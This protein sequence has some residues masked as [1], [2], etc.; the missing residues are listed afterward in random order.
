MKTKN[1]IE[2]PLRILRDNLMKKFEMDDDHYYSIFVNYKFK[3]SYRRRRNEKEE[4]KG[5]NNGAG[6]YND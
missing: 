3:N 2:K 5:G 6:E 4:D 1:D